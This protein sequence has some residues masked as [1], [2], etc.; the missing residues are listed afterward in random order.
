MDNQEETLHITDGAEQD[1]QKYEVFVAN[2]SWSNKATR[3]SKKDPQ[4]L[5]QHIQLS[6]PE[7]VLKQASKPS[8]VFNDI[9]ESYAYNA[10][11]RKFGREVCSCQVWLPPG[12]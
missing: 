10:L 5:P 7:N 8:N 3:L 4:E 12:K 1:E 9:I 2:I 11:T 6:I